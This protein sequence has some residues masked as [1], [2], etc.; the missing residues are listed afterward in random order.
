[1]PTDKSL[2]RI[3]ALNAA[4]KMDDEIAAALNGEGLRTAW[5]RP[6][7]GPL[8]YRLRKQWDI[9]A[10]RVKTTATV[11]LRWEDG[12]YSVPGAATT[13]GVYRGTIYQWLRVGRLQGTQVAKGMP[14]QIRL[15][16][17]QIAALRV[18]AAQVR[19]SKKE[20]L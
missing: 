8:I 12:T 6:F 16:E 4:Q 15:N 7:T 19:R 3:R 1:M 18:Y 10:I 9:P 2:D 13:L 17:E 11:P 20:A 5:G 14:W